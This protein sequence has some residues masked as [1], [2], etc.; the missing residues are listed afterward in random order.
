MV[1]NF[2][3]G[4]GIAVKFGK[5]VVLLDPHVSDM[6]SFVSHAHADHSPYCCV[7]KPYCTAET[8]ELIKL[9]DPTFEANVVK[10]NEKIKFDDF[11]VKLIPAGHVLG[12]VQILIE[13]DGKK[14]LYT[15]DFKTSS[16]LTCK[17]IKI[18]EAD[19]LI[20]ESTYGL[21]N[22]VFE[23]I[24]NV[25][26]NIVKWVKQQLADNFSVDLGGYHIG[27]AQEAIKLLND[28]GMQPK[29]SETI[30]QYSEVYKKHGVKLDFAKPKEESDIFVK[31]MH[32]LNFNKRKDVKVAALTGWSLIERFPFGFPLSDHC[33]FRQIMEFVEQVNPKRVYCIHG[34]TN[35]LAREIKKKFRISAKSLD[36][37][38]GKQ[39]LLID[40]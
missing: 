39:R 4:N 20:T 24:E 37:P 10:E 12:S 30:R 15:G 8:F 21:P 31:P 22:Y 23:P 35:E 25:R 16:S 9:R 38:A 33:D 7:T 3:G 26:K 5:N 2:S 1:L 18:E 36:A 17:P 6:I 14:I 32:L 13:A 28:N 19:V 40:F 34:Y 27:K 11:T 29:I